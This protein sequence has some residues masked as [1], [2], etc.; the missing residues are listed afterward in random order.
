MKPDVVEV[1]A[2]NLECDGSTVACQAEPSVEC[3]MTPVIDKSAASIPPTA[4]NMSLAYTAAP[5]TAP[6]DF[7]IVAGVQ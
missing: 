4:T 1:T 6:A 5:I 2:D 7:S 3:Q